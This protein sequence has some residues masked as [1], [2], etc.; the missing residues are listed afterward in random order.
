MAG[1]NAAAAPARAFA[2][3]AASVLLVRHAPS[4][5]EVLM[6]VRAAGHRFVPNRLVFPGGAVDPADR[7]A[8]AAAEPRPDVLAMLGLAAPPRLARAIVMAAARELHEETGL[9]FGTPPNLDGFDYLC[10]AITPP[11]Q[12]IRFNARFLVADAA[13]AQGEPGDTR[14]LQDVRFVGLRHTA[15]LDMMHVT[16]W[17]LGCLASWL[18]LAA[19]HRHDTARLRAFRN[20]RDQPDRPRIRHR[21]KR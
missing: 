17:A 1:S 14:E 12:P 4:G 19:E 3:H 13:L 18:A 16:R 8:Q 6:G 10:R 15:D 11:R 20:E 9:S 21:T 7:T 2:R 5:P